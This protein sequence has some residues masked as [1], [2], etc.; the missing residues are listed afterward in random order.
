VAWSSTPLIGSR[1]TH[2]NS[3][4]GEIEIEDHRAEVGDRDEDD[5]LGTQPASLLEG[6]TSESEL[7]TLHPQV[8][9]PEASILPEGI[10]ESSGGWSFGDLSFE[11]AILLQECL[12]E[13]GVSALAVMQHLYPPLVC[14]GLGRQQLAL[15]LC[16]SQKVKRTQFHSTFG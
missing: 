1:D 13:R 10:A 14:K 3:L 2:W 6:G 15:S 9:L 7:C 8:P 4:P 5:L 16:L 11:I 12:G